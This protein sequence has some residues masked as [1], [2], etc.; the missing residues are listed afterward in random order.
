MPGNPYFPDEYSSIEPEG[1]SEGFDTALICLNGHMVNDCSKSWAQQNSS[2]C[3]ECGAK[4]ISQCPE[5]KTDIRGKYHMPNV[6]DGTM[7]PIPKFCHHCGKAYPWTA[8]RLSAARELIREVDG[9]TE[10]EKGILERSLDDLVS[11]TPQTPVAALRFKRFVQKAGKDI[12]DAMKK[13]L[14]GLMVEAAKRQIWQ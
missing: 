12:A 1:P 5:C 13:I 8:S 3:Q 10:N 11:D 4:T 2:H 14:V 6:I 7:T 9:L